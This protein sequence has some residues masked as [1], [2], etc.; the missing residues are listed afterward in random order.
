MV[1]EREMKFEK[2]KIDNFVTKDEMRNEMIR[3][4]EIINEMIN[5]KWSEKIKQEEEKKKKNILND[6]YITK[7]ELQSILQSHFENHQNQQPKEEIEINYDQIIHEKI[8]TILPS[9]LQSSSQENEQNNEKYDQ[10]LLKLDNHI[11][12]YN[13]QN[14]NQN[15]NEEEEDEL[16]DEKINLK[17]NEFIPSHNISSLQSSQNQILEKIQDHSSQIDNLMNNN[18]HQ[19]PSHNQ[20]EEDEDKNEEKFEEIISSHISSL[21]SEL[22]EIIS[23]FDQRLC[24]F[25]EMM[26]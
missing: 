3:R 2:E 17:L 1:D 21:K 7:D 11:I 23:H 12:D 8:S 19:L 13:N 14:N 5:Q 15:Q 6:Q 18:H 9:L 20:N 26:R 24:E 22:M 16:L 25:G 10:L 4:D